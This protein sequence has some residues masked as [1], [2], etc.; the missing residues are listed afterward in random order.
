LNPHIG[1]LVRLCR[2]AA[3]P[4]LA[5]GGGGNCSV[6]DVRGNFLFIKASGIPLSEV[7][8]DSGYLELSVQALKQI[9]ESAEF[10]KLAPLAQQNLFSEKLDR[11]LPPDSGGKPSIE[12]AMHLLLDRV[13]LH[14]H[15]VFANALTCLKNGRR[16]V[17]KLM[18]KVKIY[19]VPYALPGFPLAVAMKKCVPRRPTKFPKVIFLQNHG[20][21]VSGENTRIVCDMVETIA[22]IMKGFLKKSDR[23]VTDNQAIRIWPLT[24][25]EVVYC[26]KNA[27]DHKATRSRM[28]RQVLKAHLEMVRLG[29][30][31]GQF[32][33]LSKR[34]VSDILNMDSEKYRQALVH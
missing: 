1:E 6:K 15:P 14:A 11:L 13:V 31:H 19:W 17:A 18:K 21:V 7:T 20:L 12:T 3:Q 16:L 29:R 26:G 8:K 9:F 28:A 27:R 34:Q 24:P 4:E 22:Q 25:D 23:K 33:T 2:F 10:R 30:P 5:Q 32:R